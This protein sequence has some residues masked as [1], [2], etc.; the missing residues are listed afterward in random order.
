MSS[1]NIWPSTFAPGARGECLGNDVESAA[2]IWLAQLHAAVLRLPTAE[3]HCDGEEPEV[4]AEAMAAAERNFEPLAGSLYRTVYEPNP[5]NLDDPVM[6]D[7]GDD[8]LDI[9]IDIK[10]GCQLHQQ[11]RSDEAMWQWSFMHAMHWG[12][13]AVGALAALHSR[14]CERQG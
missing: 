1:L 8:L 14:P 10:I 2:A 6:G 3:A 13:H 12:R 7:L 9:C 5:P 4:P 11:G